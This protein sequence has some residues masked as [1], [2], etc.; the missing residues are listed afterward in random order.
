MH[1]EGRMGSY[2]GHS[3][4]DNYLLLPSNLKFPNLLLLHL[5][6]QYIVKSWH[7][8]GV[9]VAFYLIYS[10]LFSSDE[11]GVQ[12]F[13]QTNLNPFPNSSP[14]VKHQEIKE[15]ENTQLS[16]IRNFILQVRGAQIT[17]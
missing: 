11:I 10:C 1:K 8:S 14:I 6:F 13:V 3:H 17:F 2:R 12:S 4:K 15:K 5:S 7:W 9:M 16:L